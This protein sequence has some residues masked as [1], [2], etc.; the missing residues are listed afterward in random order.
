MAA[1]VAGG[2]AH[3][4]GSSGIEF[5]Q[6]FRAARCIPHTFRTHLGVGTKNSCTDAEPIR[7]KSCG[8]VRSFSAS[9][10]RYQNADQGRHRPDAG[11]QGRA[12]PCPDPDSRCGDPHLGRDSVWPEYD[13][14]YNRW[15]HSFFLCRWIDYGTCR[16]HGRLGQQQQMRSFFFL[17]PVLWSQIAL[18]SMCRKANR[19]LS[20][21]I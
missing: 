2:V 14:V 17:C 1:F 4:D 21:V 12:F 15:R 5:D 18:R 19:K 16:L 11:R 9:R 7:P 13:A 20:P 6:Y 8:T 3:L 10:G